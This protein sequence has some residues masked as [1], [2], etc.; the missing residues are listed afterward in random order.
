MWQ[1]NRLLMFYSENRKC[2][3]NSIKSNSICFSFSGKLS[4]PVQVRHWPNFWK[5]SWFFVFKECASLIVMFVTIRMETANFLCYYFYWIRTRTINYISKFSAYS[6]SYK[7]GWSWLCILTKPCASCSKIF[8]EFLS[9][10][11]DTSKTST[12]LTSYRRHLKTFTGNALLQIFQLNCEL[13]P[14]GKSNRIPLLFRAA[15]W[16]NLLLLSTTPATMIWTNKTPTLFSGNNF[17]G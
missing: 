8:W 12:V 10:I 17:L 15:T 16:C 3:G 11:Q 14:F 9:F 13:L 1:L 2:K 6:C 4:S 7:N 5:I